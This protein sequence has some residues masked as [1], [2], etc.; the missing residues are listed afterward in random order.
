MSTW[1]HLLT[2]VEKAKNVITP[3]ELTSEV[4]PANKM[5][6]T[7]ANV[8]PVFLMRRR[9]VDCEAPDS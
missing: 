3:F 9:P 5:V 7:K 8:R 2:T 6:D 1:L 4:R